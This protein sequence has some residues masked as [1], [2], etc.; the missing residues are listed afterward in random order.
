MRQLQSCFKQASCFAQNPTKASPPNLG[1]S[2]GHKVEYP[3]ELLKEFEGTPGGYAWI[4]A[5]NP[6][7]LDYMGAEFILIGANPELGALCLSILKL[8]PS[9][10]NYRGRR[11]S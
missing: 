5:R 6:A 4:S 1:L 10:G 8:S 2:R 7:L 11:I 9:G 3:Q